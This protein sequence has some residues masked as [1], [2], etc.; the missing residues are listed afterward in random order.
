MRKTLTALLLAATLPTMAMAMPEGGPR[1]ERGFGGH[2]FKEL[3][4]TE[5]QRHEIG[6]LMRD[7]MKTRH[8]ITER[9]LDKLPAA[10]KKAM[11]DELKAAE[12][13]NRDAIRA[14]LKP[15][16]QKTFDDIQKKMEER[17]AERA[18]F[19]A[20]KAEKDKKAQ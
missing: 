10:E 3:N 6:K 7:Q 19:E 16:Q 15:E 1:H 2:M 8:D 17:R 13:K 14:K 9:Y 4:L 5:E 11:Q 18:E 12:T 20:W